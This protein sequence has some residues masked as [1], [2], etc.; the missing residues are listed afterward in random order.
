M[1]DSLK[2]S[3]TV[4]LLAI[5]LSLLI[6]DL[7]S[8]VFAA[9]VLSGGG[10]GSGLPLESFFQTIFKT[11][12]NII[13]PLSIAIGLACL[14]FTA[15]AGFTR[16]LAFGAGVGVAGSIAL[17]IPEVFTAFNWNGAVI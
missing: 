7:P 14:V 17:A 1:S 3:K 4:I 12:N 10:S 16:I 6:L 13:A 8:S 11:F 9:D 2:N 5:I 15:I